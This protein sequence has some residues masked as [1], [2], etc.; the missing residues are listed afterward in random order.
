MDR[1]NEPYSSRSSYDNGQYSYDYSSQQRAVSLYGR[2]SD[3]RRPPPPPPPAP[4]PPISAPIVSI[5]EV[6]TSAVEF[7]HYI[8]L[9]VIIF[10]F[11]L[12]FR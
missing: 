5:K 2:D 7:S 9:N 1:Y 3:P 10:P 4:A 11:F 6:I 12:W 8:D